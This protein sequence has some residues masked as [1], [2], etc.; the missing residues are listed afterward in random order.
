LDSDCYLT[1]KINY[2]DLFVDGKPIPS[3]ISK[4]RNDWLIKSCAYYDLDYD[5]DIPDNI[6]NVTPQ[7]CKTNIVKELILT[8]SNIPQLI[9]NGCNEFW[10][11]FC[12]I[13]KCY[14]FYDIYHV[15]IN[16]QLSNN[17]IWHINNIKND[18][19]EN[20]ISS[21]F[22]D[23]TTIFTLFQSNMHI[24]QDLYLPF[25]IKNIDAKSK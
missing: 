3:L 9:N 16:K 7:L 24:Q 22:N 18:S 17:G 1:K 12:Y 21:Q 11:Y 13:L 25:I 23:E 10:L 6:L 8:N 20:T 4:H 15:N 5:N 2:S 19:I 14:R